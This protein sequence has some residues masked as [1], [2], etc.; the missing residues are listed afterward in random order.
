MT[1]Y[2]TEPL[3]SACG[4]RLP[5]LTPQDGKATR[6]CPYCGASLDS[7][8]TKST[9]SSLGHTALSHESTVS[10]PRGKLPSADEIKF[11]LG[12][13][14]VLSSLGKGG[15]GEVFLAYDTTCGRQ[16]AIK[17][18][19]QDLVSSQQLQSRF[20]KE[21]R[22]TSQLT[23]PAIIPIYSIHVSEKLIY[24]TMP[25]VEGQTLKQILRTARQQE[26]KGGGPYPGS[27]GSSIPA[28]TRIFMTLCQ[29]VAYA[30]HE[31]VLHRDLKPENLMIGNYGQVMILDWGLAKLF[32]SS[33]EA[34]TDLPTLPR[35]GATRLGKVV[36]TATYIAPERALGQPATVQSEVYSL[37]V[38]LYQILTLQMPFGRKTMRDIRRTMAQGVFLDPAEVAPYREVPPMLSQIASKCLA[39]NVAERYANVNEL[40]RDLEIFLEGRSEWLQSTSLDIDRKADWEFQEHVL[41]AK[42]V[43]ITRHTEEADWVSLMISRLSFPGNCMIEAK[44]RLGE[45]SAGLGI[46][47]AV[48]EAAER[49][50]LADGYCLWMGSERT[51]DTRLQLSTVDVM[52]A[53]E[54][55]LKPAVWYD[56]RIEK[57]D[58]NIHFSLNNQLQFSYNSLLPTGGTHV[59]LMSRDAFYSIQD[60]RVH[61]GSQNLTVSCLSI[62][63]AFLS[64]HQHSAALAE[65]RRIAYSFPGRAVGRE[66]MLNAGITLLD[67]GRMCDD[68]E[69]RQALFDGALDEFGK[70]HSTPGAPLEYL[71]KALVYQEQEEFE[72]EIK[73]FELALRRY[74]AHPLRY[75]LQDRVIHRLHESSRAHRLAAYHFALLVVQ[76]LPALSHLPNAQ[77]LFSSLQRHWE[78]LP[79]LQR[80]RGSHGETRL[81]HALAIPLAFW[82]AKPFALAEIAQEL[83]EQTPVPI[84]DISDAVFCLI[85]LGCHRLARSL[86]DAHPALEP[87]RLLS[88]QQ[89]RN[90]I[91]AIEQALSA[92]QP[93][94]ALQLVDDVDQAS[95][96][97]GDALLLQSYRIWA[98]LQENELPRA[99]EL[100]HAF[101]EEV[102]SDDTKPLHFLYG[103]YLHATE[104]RDIA[105]IHFAGS[106]DVPYPRLWALLGHFITGR[107]G[108][109]EGWSKKAFLWEKRHLYR[110]LALFAFCGGDKAQAEQWRQRER[111]TYLDVDP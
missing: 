27:V 3:C 24:Y 29:A 66:A 4:M 49:I 11:T 92:S 56:I 25:Y 71:G 68:P 28:L 103:C 75:M 69:Q 36:G 102:L 9:H 94:V 104:G 33:E 61:C 98:L 12:P 87:L 48:P 21:A 5:P 13:Y 53:P 31:G 95:L 54:S 99:A 86:V 8:V 23:H 1:D 18:I 62:P 90:V 45:R 85:E 109:E 22:L 65:Y 88:E 89:T 60:L 79:F 91:Y 63:D 39:F 100:L 47:L 108:D 14:Q 35:P 6:F 58:G 19:R 78:P 77:R 82:V 46:L 40:I 106:L 57:I 26:K 96:S 20:L 67:Q 7:S 80:M 37:G 42:H 59:G 50:H 43:E 2:V 93:D 83:A 41:I 55:F 17:C 110:Q 64:H 15:M 72:E 16:L 105:L 10:L 74:R 101:P 107:I 70:L 84:D 44:V 32:D 30:H 111:A 81:G 73:C 97:E 52:N 38:I 76:L 34:S 51:R